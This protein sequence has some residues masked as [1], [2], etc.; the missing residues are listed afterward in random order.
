MIPINNP[1]FGDGPGNNDA[2]E[3]HI[4]EARISSVERSPAW[5]QMQHQLANQQVLTY[6]AEESL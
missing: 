6:A 5:I 2:F 4:D 1:A 3:G